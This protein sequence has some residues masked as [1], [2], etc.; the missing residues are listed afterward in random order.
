M[1]SRAL[2]ES[3]YRAAVAAVD[4]E[5]LVAEA[6]GRRGRA[7]W[8]RSL[9]AARSREF[10]FLP[11]RL[12]VL[13]LGKSAV[14]M[15]RAAAQALSDRVDDALV[16]TPAGAPVDGLPPGWRVLEASHPEADDRSLSAGE[17][18]LALARSLE[19]EDLLLVLL[20][21]GGSTLASAVP[22]DV[23][24]R[25]KSRTV[26]LLLAAGAPTADVNVVRGAL[27]R[28]K[29]GR[30]AA[31]A[32]KATVVT[33]VVS[34]LGDGG[35]HLVASGPTLGIPPTP[36]EALT[37]L[38]RYRLFPLV[39][40][41]VRTYLKFGNLPEIT[42]PGA[43]RWSVLLADVRT[44]MEGARRAAVAAG[45]E[46]RV[47]PELLVGEARA[48]ARRLAVAGACAGNLVRRAG[49]RHRRLVTV[50]GGE[51]TV[52]VK[53]P[54]TGGRCR[55]LALATAIRIAGVEG[56]TALVAGTDGV[57]HTSD[58][59]GAFVDSTTVERALARGLDPYGALD[60][61]DSGPF[62]SAL[63]DAF[64]PGPTGASVGDLAFVLAPEDGDAGWIPA[65]E[66]WEIPLPSV[67]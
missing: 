41:S 48:A 15:S 37:V 32:G 19:E 61:N 58:A 18:A 59:A 63:G 8:V 5:R 54:G 1:P 25:D 49:A 56:A 17:A 65:G 40:P 46:V 31:A 35:W 52:T 13:A 42:H 45:A 6:I 43:N 14:P 44:A 27:S 39:P 66:E 29:S 36:S 23:P 51:T 30:L 33:L 67:S 47:I 11:G 9:S 53:G 34:D 50:F 64:Q 62:F 55:E 16:V 10:V 57:D 20:S 4:P 60:A 38:D 3:L 22:G 12:V 26:G 7:F 2:L 21:G 28:I 24:L